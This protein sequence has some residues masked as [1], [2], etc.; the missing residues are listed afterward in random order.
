MN[1]L[2]EHMLRIKASGLICRIW[3]AANQQLL[4]SNEDLKADAM[5]I[6]YRERDLLNIVNQLIRHDHV[7]SVEVI[8]A[9]SGDGICVHKDWP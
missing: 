7:N 9:A 4:V 2:Y 3:R 1:L 5:T 8:D 6:M